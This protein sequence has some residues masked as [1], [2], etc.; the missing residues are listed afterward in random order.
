MGSCL[1]RLTWRQRRD[2]VRVEPEPW[3]VHFAFILRCGSSPLG[4]TWHPHR[5]SGS[6]E[7]R[8]GSHSPLEVSLVSLPSMASFELCGDLVMGGGGVNGSWSAG[9]HGLVSLRGQ[10]DRSIEKLWRPGQRRALIPAYLLLLPAAAQA[11][12]SWLLQPC[13]SSALKAKIN[14]CQQLAFWVAAAAPPPCPDLCLWASGSRPRP[15]FHSGLCER[16]WKQVGAWP[17]LLRSH[18]RQRLCWPLRPLL[19]QQEGEVPCQLGR[20]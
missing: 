10:W 7:T 1:P 9:L 12:L 18:G 6:P 15:A 13:N 8:E 5:G 14:H 17:G 4:V 16:V 20:N 3:T 19:L 2:Q 11:P